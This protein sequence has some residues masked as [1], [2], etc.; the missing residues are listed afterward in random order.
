MVDVADLVLTGPAVGEI[1]EG[2]APLVSKRREHFRSLPFA[3]VPASPSLNVRRNLVANRHVERK[4]GAG[5]QPK[6]PR[7]VVALEY[8]S[9]DKCR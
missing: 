7:S 8:G 3:C 5:G 1:V 9:H 4:Y 6:R 2:N